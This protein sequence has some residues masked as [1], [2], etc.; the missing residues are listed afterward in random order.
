MCE[1]VRV[2]A[3][4]PVFAVWAP[5][6]A[7]ERPPNSPTLNTHLTVCACVYLRVYVCVCV[8]VRL[9]RAPQRA[10]WQLVE[11]AR[12]VHAK[13]SALEGEYELYEIDAFR[14]HASSQLEAQ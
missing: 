9:H 12:D 8:C 14:Q 4:M 13:H 11:G 7:W 5:V 10:V 6:G 2:H 1:R 3:S